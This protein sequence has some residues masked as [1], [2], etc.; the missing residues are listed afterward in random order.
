M[1]QTGINYLDN[2]HIFNSQIISENNN[3]VDIFINELKEKTKYNILNNS[4]II[5]IM[6]FKE[7][8]IDILFETEKSIISIYINFNNS[9]SNISEFNK[10]INS[11]KEINKITINKNVNK[12]YYAIYLSKL[13]PIP[14]Y[15]N[16]LN[17]ENI[18]FEKTSNIKFITIYNNSK[19][20]LSNDYLLYLNILK[21]L[22]SK[23]HSLGIYYY[24]QDDTT[25]MA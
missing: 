16:I 13:E 23:L 10:F 24:D 18:N 20:V 12:K 9:K 14:S 7:S 2:Q 6:N 4:E 1:I 8:L 11:V 25:I 22:Q 3:I 15:K 17:K 5:K 19:E 21:R